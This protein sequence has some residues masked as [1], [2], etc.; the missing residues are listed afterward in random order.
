[1]II[2]NITLV[3][4]IYTLFNECN[5]LYTLYVAHEHLFIVFNAYQPCLYCGV[6]A[7][8]EEDQMSTSESSAPEAPTVA[9][10][11]S[12][13][14]EALSSSL[15]TVLKPTVEAVDANI[16]SVFDSQAFLAS[17]LDN[18]EKGSS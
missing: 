4:N 12:H 9:P 5:F 17:Q 2:E 3:F 10:E 6:I 16:K 1:M 15:F 8:E 7:Q 13:N 14:T 11:A 18:L